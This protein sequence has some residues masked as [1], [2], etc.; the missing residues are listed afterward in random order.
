ML[1]IVWTAGIVQCI[2]EKWEC[3]EVVIA[4]FKAVIQDLT[5]YTK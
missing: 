2:D 5:S 4:H 3:K 1:F